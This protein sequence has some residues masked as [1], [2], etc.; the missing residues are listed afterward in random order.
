MREVL[1]KNRIRKPPL[2]AEDQER[3][4]LGG[5]APGTL[6]TPRTSRTAMLTRAGRSTKPTQTWE[7][8]AQIQTALLRLGGP[9][10]PRIAAHR[11]PGGTCSPT[12][13]DKTQGP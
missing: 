13:C 2:P 7:N 11:R 12:G 4:A 9:N 10:R 5:T 3:E 6:Q 1:G 8:R